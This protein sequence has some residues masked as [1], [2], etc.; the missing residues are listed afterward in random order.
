MSAQG[1]AGRVEA[2][3]SAVTSEAAGRRGSRAMETNW[4]ASLRAGWQSNDPA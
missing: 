1:A 2:W 3:A 4:N